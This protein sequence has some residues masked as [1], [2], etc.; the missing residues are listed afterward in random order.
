MTAVI[1]DVGLVVVGLEHVATAVAAAVDVAAAA[2]FLS[3]ASPLN[4]DYPSRIRTQLCL[5]P[6]NSP[7]QKLVFILTPNHGKEQPGNALSCIFPAI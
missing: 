5:P 1:V 7:T 4:Q 6:E 3:A 2:G